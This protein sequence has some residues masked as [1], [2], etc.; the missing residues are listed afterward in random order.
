VI[1]IRSRDD[2]IKF[3][4]G[5]I[6]LTATPAW[7]SV[8]EIQQKTACARVQVSSRT[9]LYRRLFAR[10]GLKGDAQGTYPDR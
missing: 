9:A 1:R 10:E 7:P 2:G 4:G 6:R 3:D 5:A 8:L